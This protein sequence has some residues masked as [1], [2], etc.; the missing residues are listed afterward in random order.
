MDINALQSEKKR[1]NQWVDEASNNLNS[2]TNGKTDEFGLTL[3]EHKTPE[4]QAL[5]A[6]FNKAFQELRTFNGKYA[7]VLRNRG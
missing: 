3:D 6:E 5:K 1:L 4:Y 2:F 7:K